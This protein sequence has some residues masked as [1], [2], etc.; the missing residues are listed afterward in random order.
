[1]DYVFTDSEQEREEEK[2]MPIIVM[3]DDRTKIIMAE[4]V[5]NKE[6]VDYAVEVVKGKIPWARNK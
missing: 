5:P 3:M 1:M 2:G 6:F 4:L